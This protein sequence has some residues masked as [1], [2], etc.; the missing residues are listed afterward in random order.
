MK[1]QFNQ[2]CDVMLGGINKNTFR[3]LFTVYCGV[4]M[5]DSDMIQFKE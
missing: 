2:K 4:I 5:S 3:N 1:R